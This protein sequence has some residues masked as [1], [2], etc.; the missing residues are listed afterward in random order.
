MAGMLYS[1][2]ATATG[3]AGMIRI[4]ALAAALLVV[5]PATAGDRGGDRLLIDALKHE[6]VERP[7]RG[8]TMDQ[9]RESLG[10]PESRKGPVG[11][12]P[13]TTWLYED[14]AV[15]FE[16]DRVIRAVVRRQ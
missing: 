11:E 3:G 14:L 12:P 10:E 16:G 6:Q 4:L 15:Y 8:L 2:T 9:V 5:A 13:I 7:E 1:Q